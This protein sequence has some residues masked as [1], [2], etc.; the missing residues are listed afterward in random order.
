MMKYLLQGGNLQEP[1]NKYTSKVDSITA[2]FVKD[3]AKKVLSKLS[4][5]SDD[6]E[7]GDFFML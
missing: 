2:G 6:E 1:I 5:V 4:D 7:V 3:Y